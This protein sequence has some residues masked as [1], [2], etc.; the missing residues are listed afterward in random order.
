MAPSK[1]RELKSEAADGH[2]RA[3]DC[4]DPHEIDPLLGAAK[5]GRHGTRVPAGVAQHVW[6]PIRRGGSRPEQHNDRRAHY[7]MHS[8][9]ILHLQQ[10]IAPTPRT[11]SRWEILCKVPSR[12]VKGGAMSHQVPKC[13]A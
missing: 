7:P 1:R 3:K 13:W 9:A 10:E 12:R 5:E 11:T 2:E 8:V 6:P 4:L